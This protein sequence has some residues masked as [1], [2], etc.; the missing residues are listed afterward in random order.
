MR[1]CRPVLVWFLAF[2]AYFLLGAAWAFAIPVNGHSDERAHIIRAYAVADGQVLGPQTTSWNGFAGSEFLVPRNLLP[3]NDDCLYVPQRQS[4]ACL[5]PRDTDSSPVLTSTWTGRYSPV[6]YAFAGVPL[7]LLDGELGLLGSRLV[8][9]L[10][11]AALLAT[12]V[13]LA[14]VRQR[15]GVV[16]GLGLAMTPTVVAL[17]GAVNP[18]AWEAASA[19]LLIVSLLVLGQDR[20]RHLLV[21]AGLSGSVLLTTRT[22]GPLFFAAI[23]ATVFFLRRPR[24]S[25]LPAVW[26]TAFASALLWNGLSGATALGSVSDRFDGSL[27]FA[28]QSIVEHRLSDWATQL[29]AVFGYTETFVP[30]I[31]VIAWWCAVAL[32]IAPSVRRTAPLMLGIPLLLIGLELAYLWRLGFSQNG[33]YV[34]PLWIALL[35]VAGYFATV[36]ATRLV[37]LFIAAAQVWCLAD[38][39]TRFQQGPGQV[40]NPLEGGWQPSLTPALCLTLALAGSA[41]LVW[42]LW[43]GAQPVQHVIKQTAAAAERKIRVPA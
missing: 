30:V 33:R 9:A 14:F 15:H 24:L 11:T 10:G 7:H 26:A 39:M 20:Q 29:V 4:A 8:T 3:A 22:L 17:S 6:Y 32:F 35:V 13:M 36:V 19:A 18:N 16:L 28:V 12:A 2:T 40:I 25:W 37:A 1:S 38:V 34:L 31:I 41:G 43:T 27:T 5:Q 23:L 42:L 21:L